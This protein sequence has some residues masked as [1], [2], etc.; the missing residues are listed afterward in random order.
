MR[1]AICDDEPIFVEAVASVFRSRGHEV[2]GT[3]DPAELLALTGS[4]EF[5]VCVVDLFFAATP[6]VD[7]VRRLVIGHPSM[8]TI[9]LTGFPESPVLDGLR[10][11]AGLMLLSKSADLEQIVQIVELRAKGP[12]QGGRWPA[13]PSR[14]PGWSERLTDRERQVL[15]LLANG[16]NTAGIAR[17]LGMR[18]PTARSHIQNV[19]QKLGVHSRVEAVSVAIVRDLVS[20]V[21]LRPGICPAA[22]PAGT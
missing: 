10:Q 2:T 19:L 6:A 7:A 17:V 4:E 5:D 21:D 18:E 1:L 22:R 11:L 20:S 9:V 14:G 8:A 16:V 13:M 3:T 15:V 12:V